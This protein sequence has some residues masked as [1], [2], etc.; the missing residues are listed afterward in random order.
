MQ[1][2]SKYLNTHT[3]NVEQ[4]ED[5]LGV[6][7]LIKNWTNIVFHS[8]SFIIEVFKISLSSKAS[9][10]DFNVLF[11]LP[12]YISKSWVFTKYFLPFPSL[13]LDGDISSEVTDELYVP[14]SEPGPIDPDPS[15]ELSADYE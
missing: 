15:S 7:E 14:A 1:E 13:A 11:D 12:W 3:D 2:K 4:Y 9:S 5:V 8:Q 6:S 10:V